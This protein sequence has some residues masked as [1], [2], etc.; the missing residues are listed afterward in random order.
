MSYKIT[1]TREEEEEEIKIEFNSLGKQEGSS[2][3]G[4]LTPTT[5]PY[6]LQMVY[7]ILH[8]CFFGN[9]PEFTFDL[10][11]AEYDSVLL[12]STLQ[13]SCQPERLCINR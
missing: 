7:K 1:C 4:T 5:L 3:E 8:R 6:P 2:F 10:T 12:C 13:N 11:K 9:D